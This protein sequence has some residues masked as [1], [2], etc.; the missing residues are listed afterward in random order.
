VQLSIFTMGLRQLPSE[1]TLRMTPA[2][3]TRSA[4][5]D[6]D[7][8]RA[9][10][11]GA[12]PL[13]ERPR[14]SGL[15]ASVLH[16]PL[17]AGLLALGAALGL[18]TACENP[19]ADPLATPLGDL[20]DGSLNDPQIGSVCLEG[21]V[22]SCSLTLGE[23]DGVISC[24]EGT[25]S[26]A[27]GVFSA[28]ENGYA[29]TL[30]RAALGQNSQ[31][32][33]AASLS[34]DGQRNAGLRPLA[35]A[36][37]TPDPTDC[38]NNPCNRYC[39]EFNALPPAGLTADP[40][41]LAT[42]LTIWPEGSLASYPPEWLALGIQEPC[43]VAGDC[44][45][46]TACVDPAFG[47]CG[48]SVCTSG[49]AL[50]PGC[51][52]CASAVCALDADC[53]GTQPECSHD[54]CDGTG[55]RLD[56]DCD[57]CV[58]AVCKAHPE[59]CDTTWDDSCVGYIATECAPLGQSCGCPSG[60]IEIG[61]SCYYGDARK[62][63]DFN[64][65]AFEC[66]NLAGNW[67]L[68]QVD[69]A[70]ENAAAQ[71][72]VS[73]AGV[74]GAWLG[75]LTA[76]GET[77]KWRRNNDAFFLNDASGG[78]LQ[79]GFTYSNWGSS[80][81][82]LGVPGHG[83]A[84]SPTGDWHD[85][86]FNSELMYV[87]EG[88]R[89]FLTP[90]AATFRWGPSCVK[91]AVDTC[92]VQCP[93]GVPLD[94]GACVPRLPTELDSRCSAFDLA[95]G[96]T[97]EDAGKP[98]IPVCNHGQSP[99]PAGLELRY[100][101]VSEL[102][103]AA[104]DLSLGGKCSLAE[105]IPP[106]RC[107]VV[108]D[109][110]GLKNDSALV[111]NPGGPS[112]NTSECRVDD[113]WSVYQPLSCAA[114]TC[115]AGTYSMA[116]VQ[117]RDCAVPLRNPLGIDAKAAQVSVQSGVAQPHCGARQVLWGNSC[118]FFSQDAQTWEDADTLCQRIGPDWNLVALNSPAENK[119]VRGVTDSTR[120]VQ[121][122]FN[123]RDKEG[124]H[125]WSN[126]S[127]Q[128]WINWDLTSSQPNNS[129]PGSE[130]CTRMTSASAE[131]WED[132]DC[133]LDQHLY[134]CEGPIEDAQ[135]GCA[136][137]ELLGPNGSC[138]ALDLTGVKAGEASD[139]CLNRAPGWA[140]AQI[141]SEETAAFVTGLLNCTPTW[142]G[143]VD[144]GLTGGTALLGELYINEVGDWK[145]ASAGEQ[146]ATLCQGP[147]VSPAA[148]PVTRVSDAAACTG[149]AEFFFDGGPVAPETLRLCPETCKA[150]ADVR[151]NRLDVSIPCA[152]PGTPVQATTVDEM[153]YESD[154]EGGTP[155]WDFFYYDAV[156]PA[157][158]RVEFE[159]RTAPT[160]EELKTDTIAFTPIA[161]AH[162][163]P[164]D[165][166]HCEVDPP[167]CPVDIFVKLGAPSQQYKVLELRVKLIP[168]SSGEGPLL[169]DWRVR[170]SCPPSQ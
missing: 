88:P 17:L 73:R 117:N 39:R 140:L 107:V 40:D 36:P 53:C 75:G 106:G 145:L 90:R 111:V 152:P 29:F 46:N 12:G 127:C 136:P 3:Q 92:G 78:S 105:P 37:P 77:W 123:D 1:T 134:V 89:S 104:P 9:A 100:L 15:A 74:S 80:E 133:N 87:C 149:A 5:E 102:G 147:A 30:D 26:C 57:P 96:A 42:P 86:D 129:P 114:P 65:A 58:S 122:G 139:N 143:G 169:R 25:R 31:D 162:A 38:I 32:Y 34:S 120:D 154:C 94:L 7:T 79:N 18:L 108:S 167:N 144:P 153:Y 10:R 19:G 125:H 161:Q 48:H 163:I 76:D 141:D 91:L 27:G 43:Q 49:S 13:G 110:P 6:R 47:S 85:E 164:T 11:V 56:K 62:R 23:H 138:Y 165:T 2:R 16:R 69:D 33:G 54:P 113:N 22:E 45:F 119:W 128:S 115:E 131:R 155:I 132:T 101:P 50:A 51:N 160:I 99:A 159:V 66:I 4:H 98:Q 95:L 14:G 20:H 64:S 82:E 150:A 170:Y 59:C 21:K 83:L 60:S 63:L 52:R 72:L 93:S 142:L 151:G 124:D 41:P 28:C 166:Q 68:I 135:G 109:C 97:C 118:Y 70:A 103:K 121:I 71:T 146:R 35:L 24:Y 112:Q 84:M 168:G 116:Q 158:S 126:K 67:S 156:T 157:D 81:P 44:Q 55:T 137:G 148:Q 130:Q 61:P 8:Y